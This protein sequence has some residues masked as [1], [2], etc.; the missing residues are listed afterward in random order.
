MKQVKTNGLELFP[1][2]RRR[3]RARPLPDGGLQ[4]FLCIELYGN[5]PG[6]TEPACRNDLPDR[7]ID[8]RN[9]KL[10]SYPTLT[11]QNGWIGRIRKVMRNV[12]VASH[13]LH[14]IRLHIRRQTH[15]DRT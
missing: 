15:A 12:P 5:F 7:S 1:V 6:I 11:D 8:I 3:E 9:G 2:V 13:P 4:T 10:T 14:G